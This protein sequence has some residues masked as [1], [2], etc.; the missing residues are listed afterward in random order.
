MTKILIAGIGGVGGFLGNKLSASKELEVYFLCR[1]EHLQTIKKNGIELEENGV[2][3]STFPKAAADS[4]NDFPF[5]DIIL[6]CSK[7][8]DLESV[9]SNIRPCVNS[10]TYIIS[11][12][13]GIG[14]NAKIKTIFPEAN[15]LKSFIYI[16]SKLVSPGKILNSGKT[17]SWILEDENNFKSNFNRFI[18][19]SKEAGIN[20]ELSSEIE[21]RMWMKFS[22]ISPLATYTSAAGVNAGE[23]LNSEFHIQEL[24]NLMQEIIQLAEAENILLPLDII[25]LHLKQVARLPKDSTSSME[26]DFAQNK[27][28]ELET[29]CGYV[30]HEAKKHGLNLPH[31]TKYYNQLKNTENYA[32]HN[33]YNI[34]D[35]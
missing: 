19:I 11:L 22:F 15:L 18:E 20:L 8:Y 21:L 32:Q 14:H 1:G 28:T 30:V 4:C 9:C 13:N 25:D 27:K 35:S 29:L 12:L 33:V 16:I 3:T 10:N 7:S 26:R 17:H 31:Y 24:R 2:S 34:I 6:L 23:I 5:M